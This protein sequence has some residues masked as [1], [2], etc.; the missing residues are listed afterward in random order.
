MKNFWQK[1]RRGQSPR[2]RGRPRDCLAE[3]ILQ[4]SIPARAGETIDVLAV[5][6]PGR[7]NPRACGGDVRAVEDAI[8]QEGQS[9]R[10]RG[11][12]DCPL[13]TDGMERSIPARAGETW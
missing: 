2:V 1:P 12:R 4:R 13:D 3:A 7:V 8:T 10:V 9:P 5:L 6:P 11:R